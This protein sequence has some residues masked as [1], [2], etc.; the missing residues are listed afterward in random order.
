MTGIVIFIIR[1][2]LDAKSVLDGCFA[3]NP[4]SVPTAPAC[5]L[6]LRECHFDKFYEAKKNFTPMSFDLFREEITA[7]KEKFLYPQIV[8]DIKQHQVFRHWYKKERFTPQRIIDNAHAE[9]NP[10][11]SKEK[12]KKMLAPFKQDKHRTLK[13]IRNT[14]VRGALDPFT[15]PYEH[16]GIFEPAMSMATVN[17]HYGEHYKTLVANLN[18]ECRKVGVTGR[19]YPQ[20][21]I[22][23]IIDAQS[24]L[25]AF[26]TLFAEKY[27]KVAQK[28]AAAQALAALASASKHEEIKRATFEIQARDIRARID[29]VRGFLTSVP[30]NIRTLA[31]E[32]YTHELFFSSLSG[33]V[34]SEQNKPF[35]PINDAIQS[36]FKSFQAFREQF[37]QAALSL[38]GSGYVWLLK[39]INNMADDDEGMMLRIVTSPGGEM[40][41][42]EEHY[43]EY[44]PLLVLDVWEHAYYEDYRNDRKNFVEK[45]WWQ[46]V[47][48]PFANQRLDVNQWNEEIPLLD[49]TLK[50]STSSN[51][52]NNDNLSKIT[53]TNNDNN[54]NLS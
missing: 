42:G 12:Q 48:W 43:R 16:N 19:K 18:F 26:D 17:L 35:G 23:H 40:P 8:K 29:H 7:F 54:D 33:L 22:F 37:T 45:V 30:A 47:N 44:V 13:E 36:N 49:T 28:D 11:P 53:T 38:F 2:N 41:G 46:Y 1:H 9:R 31:I 5:G 39:K 52:N 6:M 50:A 15:L 34:Q 20:L 51:H 3:P 10:P 27:E 25:D 32:I 4:L 14:K 21:T 24:A